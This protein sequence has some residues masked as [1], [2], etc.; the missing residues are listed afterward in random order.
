MKPHKLGE[1]DIHVI[2]NATGFSTF[3]FLGRGKRDTREFETL[4]EARAD[5][6]GD[7]RAL[8]YAVL[9]SYRSAHIPHDYQ[10]Q[11]KS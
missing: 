9:G 5:A 4:E 10:L 2:E 11:N 7:P 8:V 1:R 6:K 3:R